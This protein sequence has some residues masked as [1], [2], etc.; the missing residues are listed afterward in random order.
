M[1]HLL[2]LAS[3]ERV[4]KTLPYLKK[5][6]AKS[7]KLAEHINTL[8]ELVYIPNFGLNQFIQPFVTWVDTL[9]KEMEKKQK[10]NKDNSCLED[11]EEISKS[12]MIMLELLEFFIDT[13][14]ENKKLHLPNHHHNMQFYDKIKEDEDTTIEERD[15][16]GFDDEEDEEKKKEISEH[17]TTKKTEKKPIPLT[18]LDMAS[19]L[20]LLECLGKEIYTGVRVP[21]HSTRMTEYEDRSFYF[22]EQIIFK[23]SII[24]FD[25]VFAEIQNS[26]SGKDDA[27]GKL[28][29]IEYMEMNVDK[30]SNLIKFI[31]PLVAKMS[32]NNYNELVSSLKYG[33]WNWII[34]HHDEYTNYLNN[35]KPKDFQNLVSNLFDDVYKKADSR[36]E[37]KI[38]SY[39]LC[40]LLLTLLPNEIATLGKTSS[41]PS[42]FYKGSVKLVNGKNKDESILGSSVGVELYKAFSYAPKSLY[43]KSSTS[44][45]SDFKVSFISKLLPKDKETG[46]F[47]KKTD[48]TLDVELMANFIVAD[49]V[50]APKKTVLSG[51]FLPCFTGPNELKYALCMAILALDKDSTDLIP[52]HPRIDTCVD[53]ISKPTIDLFRELKE[54][55]DAE[56]DVIEKKTGKLGGLLGKKDEKKVNYH[57]LA[58]RSL[59]HC[60]CSNPTLL[61]S[62]T[63]SEKLT[64]LNGLFSDLSL[65]FTNLVEPWVGSRLQMVRLF[66]KLFLESY[67]QKWFPSDMVTGFV[68][69]TAEATSILAKSLF[70]VTDLNSPELKELLSVIRYITFRSKIFFFN[71]STL[72]TPEVQSHTKRLQSL[73]LL[74]SSLLVCLCSTDREVWDLT[75]RCLRDIC[76]QIDILKNRDLKYL[77][78]NFFSQLTS[79]DLFGNIDEARE[80]QIQ[81]FRRIEM[82]T[83][84]N[85]L[86]FN[87]IYDRWKELVKRPE[88]REVLEYYTKMLCALGGVI[89]LGEKKK[90]PKKDRKAEMDRAAS[91]LEKPKPLDKKQMTKGIEKKGST[92]GLKGTTLPPIQAQITPTSGNDKLDAFLDDLMQQMIADDNGIRAIVSKAMARD[93]APALYDKLIHNMHSNIQKN[94]RNGQFVIDDKIKLFVAQAIEI[95]KNVV[96]SKGSTDYLALATDLENLLT[97]ILQFLS[98]FDLVLD[99][100]TITSKHKFCL[101][102]DAVMSKSEY[103]T[104]Q[105]EMKFRTVMIDKITEWT[106]DFALTSAKLEQRTDKNEIIVKYEQLNE[107]CMRGIASLLKGLKIKT[108]EQDLFLKYFAFLKNMLPKTTKKKAFRQYNIEALGGLLN[109]NISYGL[110]NYM[111]MAYHSDENIRSA[112]LAQ[113]SSL[114]KQGFS[115]ESQGGDAVES[116]DESKY[117]S[118][119]NQ[120]F[121]Y[122]YELLFVVC[123][124]VKNF[125]K[126]VFLDACSKV[127]MEKEDDLLKLFEKTVILE[128]ASTLDP[129]TLFRANS[130]ASKLMKVY[131]ARVSHSYLNSLLGDFMNDIY[132]NPVN[133]EIDP[134]KAE[135][136]GENA[137]ENQKAVEAVCEK[138]LDHILKSADLC[139]YTLRCYCSYLYKAVGEKFEQKEDDALSPKIIA[140]G[141]FLFLR[142]MNPAIINPT[143]N[144]IK[145]KNETNVNDA[146]RYSIIITKILQNLANGIWSTQKEPFMDYFTNVIKKYTPKLEVFFEEL[147]TI[148]ENKVP[149]ID[150]GSGD[151]T[152]NYEVIHRYIFNYL[153][154]MR[155]S[156]QK[157]TIEGSNSSAYEKISS[158]LEKLPKPKEEDKKKGGKKKKNDED[159]LFTNPTYEKFMS[160]MAAKEKELENINQDIFY[161][162]GKSKGNLPVA[163]F[164]PRFFEQKYEKLIIYHIAK[165]LEPI[166]TSPFC[167]VFVSTKWEPSHEIQLSTAVQIINIIPKGAQNNLKQLI[168]LNPNSYFTSQVAN[169]KFLALGINKSIV[170][171]SNYVIGADGLSQHI[172][173]SE[174]EVLEDEKTCFD[175]IEVSFADVQ[176]KNR[177]EKATLNF[178]PKNLIIV[179]DKKDFLSPIRKVDFYQL[180]FCKITNTKKE[181]SILYEGQTL[182]LKSNEQEKI[183]QCLN[184]SIERLK[185][186]GEVEL[187]KKTTAKQLSPADV[188]G[189]LL[190]ISFMNL[191]AS[192]PESRLSAYNLL[193]YMTTRFGL[194]ISSVVESQYLSI[195]YNTNDLVLELSEE[196]SSLRPDLTLEFLL[197]AFTGFLETNNTRAKTVCIG[198]MKCWV[199]NLTEYVGKEEKEEKLKQFYQTLV[200]CSCQ[201]EDSLVL[202]SDIWLILNKNEE[203]LRGAIDALFEYSEDLSI[204]QIESLGDVLITIAPS[205]YVT[206]T[207]IDKIIKLFASTEY[208]DKDTPKFTK[209]LS[210]YLKYI[211]FLC[212]RNK[213]NFEEHIHHLFFILISSLGIGDVNLRS[214]NYGICANLLHALHLKVSPDFEEEYLKLIAKMKTKEFKLIFLGNELVEPNPFKTQK[215]DLNFE[216]ITMQDIEVIVKFF[217]S[218]MDCFPS[219]A[220]DCYENWSYN[221]KKFLLHPTSFLFPKVLTMFTAIGPPNECISILPYSIRCLEKQGAKVFH[222]TEL[223]SGVMLAIYQISYRLGKLPIETLNSL[224]LV[225]IM[226]IPIADSSFYISIVSMLY[227][228]MKIMIKYSV[229]EDYEDI[230]GYFNGVIREQN[231]ELIDTFEKN[232]GLSFEKN[233][234]FALSC[235][236]MKGFSE[237]KPREITIKFIRLLLLLSNKMQCHTSLSLGFITALLPFEQ[238]YQRQ[239][240]FEALFQKEIFESVDGDRVFFFQ[241]YL[242]TIVKEL[243]NNDEILAVYRALTEAFKSIPEVFVP[244]FKDHSS[245]THAVKVYTQKEENTTEEIID[246][247]L[248]LFKSMTQQHY[249]L[250][251]KEYFT[252]F[253]FEGFK[254]HSNF[255]PQE[256]KDVIKQV[257]LSLKFIKQSFDDSEAQQFL[258]EFKE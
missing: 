229:F 44:L 222:N 201:S 205:N 170:R 257:A 70:N 240:F 153:E 208:V 15:D 63:S 190:N 135:Q 161:L 56:D 255:G 139:P 186:Q 198:Y 173:D 61:L 14:V 158:I 82:Q 183:L 104:F 108:E 74:S 243:K 242:F 93:L 86:A 9:D 231:K 162:K 193:G 88:N 187:L 126:D 94:F 29:L 8:K 75:T 155:P 220:N 58:L 98:N 145:I 245:L 76:D 113:L 210:V 159:L 11:M 25:I 101:L 235:L 151:I 204:K 130:T 214:V 19:P 216:T 213:I 140:V 246:Q 200:K 5:N 43:E 227:S 55:D 64:V 111:T 211:M 196:I 182:T 157:L 1:E 103:L 172:D 91:I 51:T 174:I 16:I 85:L 52:D 31:Q 168:V 184:N 40:A 226:F 197:E 230:G 73:E 128:T 147:S 199:N 239:T 2:I 178:T 105:S 59:L 77:N 18:K 181:F 206:K 219:L 252:E 20:M 115:L 28:R 137:E 96:E 192:Q 247:G 148:P 119:M 253:G 215:F 47:P 116:K 212:F 165:V 232:I 21:T 237:P 249:T 84:S 207:V 68:S 241:K 127:F 189:Q 89:L 38:Y 258:S 129:G 80:S 30:L 45:L 209:S 236:L 256:N 167:L 112:F 48:G 23:L 164:V 7:A 188:P 179:S 175:G 122:D 97:I 81:L 191:Q 22:K 234:S 124:T 228:I 87:G 141:G 33:F 54:L 185:R 136:R 251:T 4:A 171:Q 125:E 17:L 110:Q 46:T 156:L 27:N 142:L 169:P 138:F 180:S 202:L 26:L 221:C 144:G 120:L 218:C 66:K 69:V 92:L 60:F 107:T 35:K 166:W 50:S 37:S 32:K 238:I 39:P 163:Y 194:K 134:I 90:K 57:E 62:K 114:V 72:I 118:L 160:T 149:A 123:N 99:K 36:K 177:P 152:E 12:K 79:V 176:I 154:T 10:E 95:I 150:S 131:C 143:A 223:C 250:S 121:L 71:F 102:M 13:A 49:F 195:P 217:I 254:K 53:D 248:A 244:V 41:S 42:K 100:E 225:G 109:S 3:I 65:T 6:R 203:I 83:K 106:S 34:N 133:F 146:R 132:S 233:F 24:N 78:Y 117:S 67:I 224:F